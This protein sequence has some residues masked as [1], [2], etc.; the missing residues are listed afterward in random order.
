M[1][2]KLDI[3]YED[4]NIIVIN[5]KNNLLT[6]GTTKEKENTLYHKVSEYVKKQHKSNKIFIV[7]RL[8]KET[9]G[10]ILF[11]K[12]EKVKKIFQDNW[13]N[14]CKY[15]GY[16]AVVDG[17][18]KKESDKLI[19]YLKE[20]SMFITYVTNENNKYAKKA[21]TNYKVIQKNNNYSLLDINIETG[22]KNQIRVQLNEI[23]YGIIGDKKYGSK[24][25]PIKR[26][27]LHANKLVIYNPIIK[28]EMV[29]E[30]EIPSLFL[31]LTKTS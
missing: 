30:T 18:I 4:K 16:V 1:K 31:S 21:I 13:E 2:D 19:S 5:K 9:S 17:N 12:N 25:D 29:F 24:K 3:I 28:K 8:D 20:N 26:L 11:A 15:R 14:F 23:G 22:R 10:I 6:V 27:G 7:H